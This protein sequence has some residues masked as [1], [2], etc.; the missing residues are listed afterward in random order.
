MIPVGARLV[1]RREIV[2]K[3]VV[4]CNRT[5]CDEGRP[6]SIVS[7]ILEDTMPVD[8]GTQE[9]RLVCELVDYLNGKVISLLGRNQGSRE[10]AIDESCWA[11]EAIRSDDFISY[12]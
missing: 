7:P 11:F 3:R 6:V 12:G 4:L 1:R 5:L 10:Y 8:T 2:Y 9:H